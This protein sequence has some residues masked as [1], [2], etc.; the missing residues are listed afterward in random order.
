MWKVRLCYWVVTLPGIEPG[1]APWEGAVLTAW[2]QGRILFNFRFPLAENQP[3]PPKGSPRLSVGIA[4]V[5]IQSV[6]QKEL[7]HKLRTS[8]TNFAPKSEK[9]FKKRHP[10]VPQSEKVLTRSSQ[11]G[12]SKRTSTF[13]QTEQTSSIPPD[14]RPRS[15]F[16]DYDFPT[17]RTPQISNSV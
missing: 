5:G 6:R 11:V 15:Y 4:P 7:Y 17:F 9:I 3:I 14:I 13:P 10:P 8:A 2:P 1:I 12:T 16:V